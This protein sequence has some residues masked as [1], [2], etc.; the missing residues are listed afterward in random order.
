MDS[1]GDQKKCCWSSGLSHLSMMDNQVGTLWHEYEEAQT[2]EALL[3]KDFDKLEMIIQA[4]S[5]GDQSLQAGMDFATGTLETWMKGELQ[6]QVGPTH[7]TVH[8]TPPCTSPALH[9]HFLHLPTGV[10]T[11]MAMICSNAR[12]C[13]QEMRGADE[14]Q[15]GGVR[16]T[17]L[18]PAR[19]N[20]CKKEQGGA[21]GAAFYISAYEYE[22]AQPDLNLQEFFDSTENAIKTPLG[23]AWADELRAR[24]KAKKQ[25]IGAG[26]KVASAGGPLILIDGARQWVSR[27]CSLKTAH[28]KCLRRSVLW[29]GLVIVSLATVLDFNA[30]GHDGSRLRICLR[31][32]WKEGKQS[33]TEGYRSRW[34]PVKTTGC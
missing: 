23:K 31:A 25:E 5:G 10:L 14:V 26:G 34:P 11:C 6:L 2:P 30:A 24:R 4:W 22:N 29:S 15:E 17:P 20:E 12:R 33:V 16:Y 8:S 19:A 28:I 1:N 18:P 7:L 27:N 32:S 21:G 9:A 3:V 13:E